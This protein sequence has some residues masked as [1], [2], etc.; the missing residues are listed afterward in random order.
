M[1]NIL[2]ITIFFFVIN[3][4]NSFISITSLHRNICNKSTFMRSNKD[5]PDTKSLSQYYQPKTINQEKYVQCLN[6]YKTKILFVI[7]PAGTGKTLFACN[8]A[9]RELKTGNI[10]KIV[11]TR[12]VV[13]VE[14]DIGFLP[15]NI[16]RKMDPW[17]RPIFDVFLE[18]YSQRDI[19]MMVQNNVIE[20][21]P[22]A[23]MRGRTFKKA[24]IIAD[25]MQNSSPNQMLMLTTRIGE[26]SKMVI[27][28]DLQQSDR[29]QNNGLSDFMNKYNLHSQYLEYK[30]NLSVAESTNN[31]S[32]APLNKSIRLIELTKADIE[33]SK[34]VVDILE[35]YNITQEKVN[36]LKSFINK[37]PTILPEVNTTNPNLPRPIKK[38]S[39]ELFMSSPFYSD[40]DAALIPIHHIGNH[41][42]SKKLPW[43]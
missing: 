5:M 21:S 30:Y 35:V 19:D 4:C 11:L 37:V 43:E 12:P 40:S 8:T 36:N 15:G 13:P 17:T 2:G 33:R 7:G 41:S 1:I 16:N 18:F 20:I 26:G 38:P 29:S 27:T 31:I 23:Y 3:A 34:V 10:Q 6:D 9:I 24:F 14:E 28:G 42:R 32:Y 25:E 22:L 39:T